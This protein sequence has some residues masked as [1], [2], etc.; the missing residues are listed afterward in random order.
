MA[1]TPSVL[2]QAKYVENTL[3]T[4]YT[5]TTKILLDHIVLINQSSSAH[6]IASMYIVEN[7]DSASNKNRLLANRTIAQ[8][9]TYISTE[10]SSHVLETG[11]FIAA[12]SDTASTLTIR[13]CG[14][15]IT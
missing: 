3:T 15:E 1:A 9:E 12:I 5:A 2:V 8:E 4:Q 7:G 11:D 13:I 10:M 6:V 14:R